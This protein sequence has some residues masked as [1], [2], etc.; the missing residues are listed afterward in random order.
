MGGSQGVRAAVFATVLGLG[1]GCGGSGGG[2]G[3]PALVANLSGIA[4]LDGTVSTHGTVLTDGGGPRAGDVDSVLPGMFWRQ[5]FTFDRSPIPVG[6]TIVSAGLDVYQ[7]AVAGNPYDT[8]G[9]LVLDYLDYGT[10]LDAADYDLAA[11]TGGLGPIS[12]TATLGW[13]TLDV[14]AEVRDALGAGRHPQFR[15]RWSALFIALDGQDDFVVFGD[16]EGS[17]G[18]PSH[19]PLLKVVYTN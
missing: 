2:G 15:V 5:F 18:T 3:T 14:T 11:I 8:H 13:K 17:W 1:V 12:T 6:A 9:D 7:E 10:S 4:A 16:A 19:P